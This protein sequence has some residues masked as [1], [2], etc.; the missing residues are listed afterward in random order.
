MR[1]P[2][3]TLDA[4]PLEA[5]RAHLH[6]QTRRSQAEPSPPGPHPNQGWSL[7]LHLM[8][9]VGATGAVAPTLQL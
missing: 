5:A 6:L 4:V 1:P 7:G 8:A 2:S 9:G 3:L